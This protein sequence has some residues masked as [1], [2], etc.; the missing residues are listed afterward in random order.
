MNRL[1]LWL[2][3]SLG[4]RYIGLDKNTH[5]YRSF[6]LSWQCGL[7]ILRVT[8]FSSSYVSCSNIRIPAPQLA[9]SWEIPYRDRQVGVG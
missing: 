5:N 6:L 7:P 4:L 9:G 8:Q 3:T 1:V 2:K